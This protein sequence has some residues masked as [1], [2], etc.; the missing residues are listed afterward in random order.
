MSI[1]LWDFFSSFIQRGVHRYGE[2][3]K[4][5]K[6]S[7]KFP[8]FKMSNFGVKILLLPQ[9]LLHI[10][11]RARAGQIPGY[12]SGVR[13][14]LILMWGSGEAIF[15]V[16]DAVQG[17]VDDFFSPPW[18]LFISLVHISPCF[19]FL[20][21]SYDQSFF[22]LPLPLGTIHHLFSSFFFFPPFFLSF[23]YYLLPIIYLPD[24]R[25]RSF[26]FILPTWACSLR[27]V[28]LRVCGVE[29]PFV[30]K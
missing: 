23:V 14:V 16:F 13:I 2:K 28:E 19:L 9:H 17:R 6:G 26:Y 11:L 27:W 4:E 18:Y 22:P 29:V 25:S 30:W 7:R 1:K 5:K 21:I 24:L 8:S 20:I 10:V 15:S 12:A 3:R